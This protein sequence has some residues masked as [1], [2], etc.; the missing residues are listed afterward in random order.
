[1]LN[2]TSINGNAFLSVNSQRSCGNEQSLNNLTV[3]SLFKETD[4]VQFNGEMKRQ[5]GK[6]SWPENTD[7]T[8]P[9]TRVTFINQL[10]KKLDSMPL[11]KEKPLFLVSF[12]SSGLL[13]EY[14]IHKGLTKA[15]FMNLNWRFINPLYIDKQQN[16]EEVNDFAAKHDVAVHTFT[17]DEDILK[18]LDRMFVMGRKGGQGYMSWLSQECR[19]GGM[20]LL[21]LDSSA[22]PPPHSPVSPDCQDDDA[23]LT[24]LQTFIRGIGT[25][26]LFASLNKN[27]F[28]FE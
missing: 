22:L 15:G 12:G 5:L 1:M 20:V 3:D 25:H 7:G 18:P 6:M 8:L 21:S 23:G 16:L 26:Y 13:T 24:A 14:Y 10:I 2:I 9:E 19:A 11:P 17:S 4:T 28:T 27:E